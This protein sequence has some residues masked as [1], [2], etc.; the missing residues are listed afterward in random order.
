MYSRIFLFHTIPIP[1]LNASSARDALMHIPWKTVTFPKTLNTEWGLYDSGKLL[2]GRAKL[3][4]GVF[5]VA[6]TEA[7]LQALRGV[8]L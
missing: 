3:L 6:C 8:R 2:D 7:V 5:G 1:N 4:R